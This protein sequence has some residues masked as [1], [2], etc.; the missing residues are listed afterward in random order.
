MRCLPQNSLACLRVGVGAFNLEE[1]APRAAAG[2][3][4]EP[5]SWRAGQALQRTFACA[6]KLL[7]RLLGLKPAEDEK[8]GGGGG[9]GAGGSLRRRG[10]DLFDRASGEL[11]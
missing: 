11:A 6:L 9:S 8:S 2:L 4:A 5:L 1:Q 3:P 10:S 7:R